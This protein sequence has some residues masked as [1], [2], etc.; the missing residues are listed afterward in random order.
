MFNQKSDRKIVNEREIKEIDYAIQVIQ[1]Q[2]HS[3]DPETEDWQ[4]LCDGLEKLR[5]TRQSLMDGNKLTNE[6]KITIVK[7]FAM[8]GLGICVAC[9][10]WVMPAAEKALKFLAII[11][12]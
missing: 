2:M 11:P 1:G 12:K 7:I 9:L 4:R 6:Q 10:T 5:A 3:I 8:L